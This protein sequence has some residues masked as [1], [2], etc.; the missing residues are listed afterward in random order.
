MGYSYMG[1]VRRQYFVSLF[2]SLIPAYVIERLFWQERG[3][4]V[5]GVVWCEVIYALT[6]IALEIPS[7]VL[8]DRFGRKRMLLLCGVFDVAEF[9][10]LLFARD[11]WAFGLAV[12]LA[13]VGR[14]FSSGTR[15]A[16]L[17]DS[18]LAEGRQGEFEKLLG[19]LSAVDFGGSVAAA[20]SGGVLANWLGYEFNYIVSACAMGMALLVILTLKEP[21]IAP[22]P[23]GELAGSLQ[24]AKQA[25]AVFRAE[26]LVVLY[27]LTGAVLGACMIYPD[28]FWQLALESAGVP[29]VFFGAVGAGVSL[30]RIPGNLLAYKLQEKFSYRAILIAI[31]LV[32][33][34]GY[35]VLF[36]TRSALCLV[37]L[38]ALY[39]AAG[40][41][42][43]LIAGYLH[44]R[45]ESNVRATTE[46][47]ASLALRLFSMPAGLVFGY[48]SA[49]HTVFA[50]FLP[51]GTICLGWLVVFLIPQFWRG[52]PCGRSCTHRSRW[53]GPAAG[54]RT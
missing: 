29:V 40:V 17:Y 34:A 3:V 47:F 1:N 25:L 18:L 14:S 52:S 9:V 45:T 33:A 7:G 6:V 28:E 38:A 44:H 31:L 16:L 8:A 46:S 36:F 35:A 42:E 43:P 51:L 26:P 13:G 4:G 23:E 10:I 30:C 41:S 21:P 5:Q 48:I 15:N 37:P 19:R 12:F 54:P 22:R 32:N 53:T 2:Q 24:Y 50:G 27:C 39:L 49:R 11:F 20:L